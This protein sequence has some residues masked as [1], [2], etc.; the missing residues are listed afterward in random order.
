MEKFKGK[1]SEKL[2]EIAKLV[3]EKVVNSTL[4][5]ALKDKVVDLEQGG[6][7]VATV[8]KKLLDKAQRLKKMGNS[9][10]LD[11]DEDEDEDEEEDDESK[12][13]KE[14]VPL[15]KT[16]VK[17]KAELQGYKR[18][19]STDSYSIMHMDGMPRSK[20]CQPVT[21]AGRMA[22]G[23]LSV[24]SAESTKLKNEL[25]SFK[26]ELD[27][28]HNQS[29]STENWS[30]VYGLWFA[31]HSRLKHM[32]G[33]GT[34]QIT[35]RL[36]QDPKMV[37]T[38]GFV[39]QFKDILN[40]PPHINPPSFLISEFKNNVGDRFRDHYYSLMMA[41]E[42]ETRTIDRLLGYKSAFVGLL[43]FFSLPG[44]S[45]FEGDPLP[46]KSHD[47]MSQ[48]NCVG[49]GQ[50]AKTPPWP[51]QDCA[52]QLRVAAETSAMGGN[53]AHGYHPPAWPSLRWDASRGPSPAFASRGPKKKMQDGHQKS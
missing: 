52:Q 40:D 29:I 53:Q 49:F 12:K 19:K 41:I 25:E 13:A 44:L 48:K 21:V 16:S 38:L 2:D 26:K 6:E 35:K 51:G 24:S 50:N 43:A 28:L 27:I 8:I 32:K 39:G 42:K 17:L 45:P 3:W 37:E 7:A 20:F 36:F 1:L 47:M 10:D 9:A 33:S 5:Q 11:E 31:L 46:R 23:I 4:S 18:L 34:V 15:K 30:E 22:W 14:S